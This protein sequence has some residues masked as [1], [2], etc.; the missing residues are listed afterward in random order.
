[1][2][3][4]LMDIKKA[5]LD[6]KFRDS[7]P[8]ELKEDIVKFLQNPSCACNLPLYKKIAKEHP[9]QIKNY[10]GEVETTDLEE[11]TLSQNN[12]N[13]INCTAD[14]LENKL[15]KL[16]PGR[17]QIAIARYENQITLIVNELEN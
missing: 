5:L 2:K 1:M 15:K 14:E 3:I 9:E 12:W 17:K 11:K 16:P 8:L 4:S 7:F 13:V 10:F 6:H